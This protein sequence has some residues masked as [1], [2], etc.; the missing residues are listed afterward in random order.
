M[1]PLDHPEVGKLLPGAVGAAISTIFLH[2]ETWPRR[3]AMAVAGTATARFGGSA[4]S[5]WTGLDP[6]FAGFLVGLFSM[7]IVAGVF[8]T[9]RSLAL[10]PIVTEW[11]RKVLGLPPKEHKE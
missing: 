8:E 9:W 1:N 2:Q 10:G 7:A 11:I 6:S 4:A 5:A 3:I